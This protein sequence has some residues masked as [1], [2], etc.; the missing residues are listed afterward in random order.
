MMTPGL[1]KV[2]MSTIVHVRHKVNNKT[3]KWVDTNAVLFD[4]SKT[5]VVRLPR[6]S[7]HQSHKGKKTIQVDENNSISLN[8]TPIWWLGVWID[9]ELIFQYHYQI[10]MTKAKMD[11]GRVKDIT[12]KFRLNSENAKIVQIAEVWSVVQCTS[13]LWWEDDAGHE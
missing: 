3:T 11:H 9:T 8:S 12:G 4:I 10:V 1:K 13:E 6:Q 2:M 7:I 5:E